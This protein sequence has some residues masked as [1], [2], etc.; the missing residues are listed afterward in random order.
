M[1]YTITTKLNYKQN[2]EIIEYFENHIDRYSHIC[3]I[4]W[5]I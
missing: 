3:R 2:K 1:K 4:C 5:H